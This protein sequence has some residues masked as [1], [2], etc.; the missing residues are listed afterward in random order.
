MPSYVSP[1]IPHAM[2]TA[3]LLP[4]VAEVAVEMAVT[5]AATGGEAMVVEITTEIEAVVGAYNY[6]T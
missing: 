5:E 2:A 3:A 4:L 1:S 6:Q